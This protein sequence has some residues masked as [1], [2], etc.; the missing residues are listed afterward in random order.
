[1]KRVV[2]DIEA[3]GLDDATTI[4]CIVT[5][6]LDTNEVHVF[7]GEDLQDGFRLYAKDLSLVVGHNAIS[8][9]LPC[10]RRLIG[11]A[12]ECDVF[13]TLVVSRL[14]DVGREGGHSLDNWGTILK[15]P[16]TSYQDFSKYTPQMREYCINDVELTHKVYQ[17]L[18]KVLDR[19]PGVFDQALSVEHDMQRICDDMRDYGFYFNYEEAK[20]IDKELEER[21]K[22]L[23]AKI[24]Q[25]FPPK[26]ETVQL[27]TK[28][29]TII[30]EFNPGSPKQIVDRLWDAGW[31]PTEKTKTHAKA[32]KPTDRDRRYGWK[33]NELNVSTLPED[34]P[35][36]C[37]H[38]VEHIL[39]SARRRTL[40]EWFDAY[41]NDDRRIHGSINPLGARSHRC[42]HSNPNTGNIAAK[43]SI[44]YSS[45]RLRQL[46]IDLGGRMRELWCTPPGSFLVG[47]DMEGAHL[48]IFAHLVED[49]KFI[50]A[51]IN[52]RKEDGTDPHSVNKRIL[53]DTCVD[54]DRAKTFIFTFL[55]GGGAGK[56]SEIFGCSIKVAQEALLA[57]TRAYPGLARLKRN[58]F[59]RDAKRGYF[60]GI[61]GRY[62]K[63]NSEHLMTA[64][65]LQNAE[66]L[67]M[68]YSMVMFKNRMKDNHPT[69]NWHYVG[70]VHDEVLC[71]VKGTKDE[72]E[73][74]G[75]VMAQCIS[76]VGTKFKFKCPLAGE[77]KVATNWLGAH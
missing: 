18:K 52:G 47:I 26:I 36:G 43:K 32:K 25:S 57:F 68:K 58:I 53:G 20:R 34:A 40:K 42:T 76:D 17:A 50:E 19:N 44:K 59:P 55:N 13:D 46:A 35:E 9:D 3:N 15:Y 41:S 8:Y 31:K 71:E 64:M 4:W 67:V 66:A 60:V 69:I 14:L 11:V 51:L 24:Q 65:V 75:K 29:K 21:I 1:V 30:S 2:L 22:E 10:I 63:C 73:I 56:V 70:F 38:L 6:D 48:R 72:A 45:D 23:D 62:V 74:C 54:R 37:K 33:I 16:K 27:K 5:K 39:L 12:I 61:D 28:V 77:Y 49:K 7:E